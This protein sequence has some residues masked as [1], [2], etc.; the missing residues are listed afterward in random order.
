M[1]RGSQQR[2]LKACA[3]RVRGRG[4]RWDACL[5]GAAYSGGAHRRVFRACA[6]CAARSG[7]RARAT[8][9]RVMVSRAAFQAVVLQAYS[10]PGVAARQTRDLVVNAAGR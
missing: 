6:Q 5:K 7:A 2:R 1:P 10:T 9:L 3:V 4:A 8:R